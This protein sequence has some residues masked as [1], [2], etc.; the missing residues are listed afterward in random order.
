M[1]QGESQLMINYNALE[2]R[3]KHFLRRVLN[4]MLQSLKDYCYHL[5]SVWQK[6]A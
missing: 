4:V 2:N 6:S 3:E 5:N 1:N